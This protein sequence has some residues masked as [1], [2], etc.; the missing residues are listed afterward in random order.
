MRALIYLSLAIIICCLA[1]WFLDI[2][3]AEGSEGFA[4]LRVSYEALQ[5]RLRADLQD[6]CDLSR[7]V[8]VQM[9]TM[10]TSVSKESE[11]QADAHIL[12]TYKDIYACTDDLAASR[13]SCKSGATISRDYVPCSTY[14]R[15]P[16]WNY[17][18]QDDIAVALSAV[19]DDLESRLTS[20]LEYYDVVVEKLEYGVSIAKEPPSKPPDSSSSPSTNSKG[21][22]WGIG[23]EGFAGWADNSVKSK[24]PR[25]SPA[26][27]Q[28]KLEQERKQ[29]LINSASSCTILSLDSEI[30]RINTILDSD[31]LKKLLAKAKAILKRMTKVQADIEEIKKKWDNGAPKKQYVNFQGGD[32][33]AS[34]IFSMQQAK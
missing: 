29:S 22:A 3:Q 14:T 33:I 32:R 27:V 1:L 8:K 5:A 13:A 12:Q 20:E 15:T 30:A 2:S 23:S 31:T 6:Y 16:D 17:R 19:P 26:A 21:K 28:A 4:D 7:F 10:Y 34:L 24:A 9:K 18:N 11:E 25:C